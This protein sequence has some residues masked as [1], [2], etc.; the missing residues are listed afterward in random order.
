MV[1][2]S[3]S[4]M[5][6]DTQTSTSGFRAWKRSSR[7]SSH[8]EAKAGAVEIEITRV[9]RSEL[10]RSWAPSM[11]RSKPSRRLGMAAAAAS[12]G[13]MCLPVRRN[14]GAPTQVSTV[15]TC[16]VMALGVTPNSSAARVRLRSLTLASSAR[17]DCRAGIRSAGAP[18]SAAAARWDRRTPASAEA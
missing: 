3:T 11:M 5:S 14:S 13:M 4:F 6:A 1:E 10:F 9:L 18:G 15:R 2:K 8:L 16:W 7:G 17:S 12:V